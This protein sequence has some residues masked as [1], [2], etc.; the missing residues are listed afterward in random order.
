ME[1][2]ES[3]PRKLLALLL[4]IAVLYYLLRLS[5]A[6]T[7]DVVVMAKLAKSL[8]PAPSGWSGTNPCEWIGVTCDS[9]G[10]VTA[11]NLASKS[12]SGELPSELNQLSR[13]KFLSLQRNRLSGTFPPLTNLTSLQQ[14][15][16]E[17]NNFSAVP[18]PF[19]AGLTSLQTLSLSDN[20]NLPPWRLPSTLTDSTTLTSLYADNSSLSGYIPDIFGSF[21]SLQNLRLSYN[22]LTGSLPAS[23]AKSGIQNLWLNNQDHGLSG[24]VDVLSSMSQLT[25]VW[26][27]KNQF[28]GP[29]PDL[30][31]CTS[32]F[33]L[34]LRNNELTGPVPNSL[35]TLPKLANVS[36]ENNKLQGPSP[37][38]HKGVLVSL[39]NTNNFCNPCDS[40]I[41]TLLEISGAFGYP[42]ALA[43]SWSGNDPCKGWKSVSCDPNGAVSVLNFGKQGWAGTISPAIANLSALTTLL[44]NDNNLTGSIPPSLTKLAQLKT[45]DVSNNNISGKVPVFGSG[46]TV[47]T[48]GNPFV[49]KGMEYGNGSS[50]G[51]TT[52]GGSGSAA[53]KSSVSQWVIGATIVA[54]VVFLVVSWLVVYKQF[55]KKRSGKYVWIKGSRN[56]S[57]Q[58][59]KSDVGDKGYSGFGSELPS[60]SNA[61]NSSIQVYD[62]GN[63][64]ILVEVL[65]E[66]TN[67]FSEDNI[68]GRGGFGV[69]YRGQL[70]DGTQIAVK[71][72]EVTTMASSKGLS[73]FQAE[74][75]VLSRV[76]HRHLVALK[77]FC[78]DGNERLLV[79]EYMPQGT[80]G[81]H[82][83]RYR[84]LGF[85]PLTWKQRVT[86]V[87]DV[88]RGVEYLHSLAQQS[89][90]H[91]DLKPSNILLGD[92]MRA[93][94]SDFGLVR[95]A[96]DGKYSVETRLAGTFGYLA[97]EYSA[98]G[99]VT[100]KIDVFAFGVVLM[101]IIT[102]KKALD[103]TLPDEESYLVSWF[104]RLLNNKNS[105][106]KSLDPSLDPDEETFASICKVAE[107][108]GHCTAP[109]PLQRPDMGHAVNTLSPLVD[110]WK[111]ATR[112]DED[113]FGIDLHMSL[114]Q[115]LQKW[116]SSEDTSSMS[117]S[118]FHNGY[119]S[120][121]G[122][123]SSFNLKDPG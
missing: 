22:N 7:E 85:P 12:L 48:S 24:R 60:Q 64:A 23:F 103:N 109:E 55:V 66:V 32:L 2:D 95:N 11:I 57:E 74:I 82:L 100:T 122:F 78:V 90:I 17:S 120:N 111:P 70:P 50:S 99:K 96:P 58:S 56:R 25:Q 18:S 47:N 94:V 46:V 41:T 45:L 112:D 110:Q 121:S 54:A 61:G 33:D 116:Q 79:Y 15:S 76:R 42:M 77:G 5:A 72:M 29:I 19:L 119:R 105:I 38:F 107:L 113:S 59:T 34:S 65:R 117:S 13:L 81:Q 44:L 71:R 67:N 75:A 114:P 52:V 3:H 102:G 1:D 92:D 80:L 35:T 84:E 43:D 37:N 87:L 40:Q 62:G 63:V 118:N 115:A 30:S 36:L 97:P 73:E 21:P 20:P 51:G 10:Y 93:K 101:E 49:G 123:T 8:S 86:I 83:F 53:S 28:S 89:F 69:V 106:R 108:A 6:A 98:T 16:L 104:R 27:H 14:I 88:A 68:L 9:S 39:G 26:L 91:R 31:A 4:T